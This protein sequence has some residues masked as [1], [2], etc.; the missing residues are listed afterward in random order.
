MIKNRDNLCSAFNLLDRSISKYLIRQYKANHLEIVE[1]VE[2]KDYLRIMLH[3]ILGLDRSSE[4]Y[5]AMAIYSLV[6]HL[7]V[8]SQN[9]AKIRWIHRN[10]KDLISKL[11]S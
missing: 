6:N 3:G 10:F 7:Y 4:E 2:M 11:L 8:I 9:D 5:I 1:L